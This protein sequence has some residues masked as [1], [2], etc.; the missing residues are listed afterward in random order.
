MKQPTTRENNP[1]S[2]LALAEAR[3]SENYVSFLICFRTTAE[4][5]RNGLP[6]GVVRDG[7]FEP[8]EYTLPDGSKREVALDTALA[9]Q[10]IKAV[11]SMCPTSDLGMPALRPEKIMTPETK[12]PPETPTE[13][14]AGKGLASPPC[15]PLVENL[16]AK[17]VFKGFHGLEG[18]VNSQEFWDKQPYGTRLYYGDE[19]G[20]YLHRS[21][22]ETAV[23]ILKENEKGHR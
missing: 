12:S 17:G 13:A 9:A 15:S 10:V 19:I 23:E 16:A 1:D 2:Q 3:G 20:D 21:I 18:L 5:Y 11:N 7:R 14:P 22:L 4:I 8:H 6:L